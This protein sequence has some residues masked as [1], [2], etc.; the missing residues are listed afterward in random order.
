[1][2]QLDVVSFC[3]QVSWLSLFIVVAY[4]LFA[5]F[6]TKPYN[7]V[8]QLQSY[9]IKTYKLSFNKVLSSGS[10]SRSY[11][12][13][14]NVIENLGLLCKSVT[15]FGTVRTLAAAPYEKLISNFCACVKLLG[16]TNP[17]FVYVRKISK[18]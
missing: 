2:P 4:A 14:S 8:M 11:S 6:I 9:F 7:K 10:D 15:N 12:V 17:L 1:M 13:V 5:Y 18:S 3:N 16:S